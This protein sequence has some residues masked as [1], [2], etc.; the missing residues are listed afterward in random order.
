MAFLSGEN[1]ATQRGSYAMCSHEPRFLMQLH[2]GSYGLQ[3]S[4]YYCNIHR[5]LESYS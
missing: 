1:Q 2:V 5:S 3:H 4:K